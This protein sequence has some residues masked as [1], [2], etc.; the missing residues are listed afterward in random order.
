MNGIEFDVLIF[1]LL[2]DLI[3]RKM[4]HTETNDP[5]AM[6]RCVCVG[7]EGHQCVCS[8]SAYV[9]IF[10]ECIYVRVWSMLYS[11]QWLELQKLRTKAK[12]KVDTKAS[13]GRKIRCVCV[14]VC[15]CGGVYCV[16]GQMVSL[17]LMLPP[18]SVGVLG[19]RFIPSWLTSWHPYNVGACLM[20]PGKNIE[21]K[22]RCVS[23]F[24]RL[25]LV[26]GALVDYILNFAISL[27]P[28]MICFVR[29]LEEVRR[30]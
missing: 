7:G 21:G 28:E 17:H 5:I 8:S 29:C 25:S 14:C 13:K 9:W 23:L 22:R 24:L 30:Q 20:R 11:R 1:Q 16:L 26:A 2:K 19:T 10:C 18:V 27:F 15:V 3:E 6:G 12:K 4:N